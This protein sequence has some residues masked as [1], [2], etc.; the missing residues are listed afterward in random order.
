MLMR[1]NALALGKPQAAFTV[2]ERIDS[3]LGARLCPEPAQDAS[4]RRRRRVSHRLSY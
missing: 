2:I 4:S 1:G 3:G